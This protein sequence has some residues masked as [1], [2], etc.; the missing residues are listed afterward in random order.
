MLGSQLTKAQAPATAS[1]TADASIQTGSIKM[2]PFYVTY[3]EQ[4][5]RHHTEMTLLADLDVF[6]QHRA[7]RDDGG[8]THDVKE[9]ARRAFSE[10]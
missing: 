4:K 2:L 7:C 9:C 3:H 10:Q 8:P 6:W 1:V 5:E